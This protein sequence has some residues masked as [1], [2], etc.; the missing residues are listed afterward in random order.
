[1][2]KA[3][4]F[5]CFGVLI[6]D[7]LEAIVA[8]IRHIQPDIARQ[9]VDTVQAASRGYISRQQSTAQVAELLGIS[10]E[11]YI[12]KIRFGEVKNQAL[13]DSIVK[14]RR[15]Y[16]TAILSNISSGGLAVRFS[17]DELNRYFDAVVGSGDIGYAKP[18]AQAY[19]IVADKLSVRM[20]ECIFIDDREDYCS[21]AVSVGMKAVLYRS[22]KQLSDDLK[23]RYGVIWQD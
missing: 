17:S 18:A 13:L 19:E 7:A 14:L 2:I 3:I 4:I 22:N 9:I 12:N 21:G 20:E 10:T 6:T 1:M 8:E 16:K 23:S 15:H 5:D 11:A